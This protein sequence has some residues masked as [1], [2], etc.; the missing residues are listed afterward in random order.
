MIVHTLILIAFVVSC[1]TAPEFNR[2]N[3]YDPKSDN[4]KLDPPTGANYQFDEDGNILLFWEDKSEVETGYRV[5]KSL[6]STSEFTLLAELQENTISF[7]DSTKEFAYPTKYH[8][9]SFFNKIISDTLTIDVDFGEVSRLNAEFNTD[10]S[11]ITLS[12]KDDTFIADGFILNKKTDINQETT[13]VA[14]IPNSSNEYTFKAPKLGFSHNYSLTPFKIFKDDT[15][16]LQPSNSKTISTGP[17]DLELHLISIDSLQIKWKDISD[18]E[19]HFQVTITDQLGT[20]NFEVDKNK[21]SH[22]L[23]KAFITDD[24]VTISVKGVHNSLSSDSIE[25]SIQM[26]LPPP[27]IKRFDIHFSDEGTIVVISDTSLV[28]REKTIYRKINDSEFIEVGTVAKGDSLF[29]D[30][31]LNTSNMY[32]YKVDAPLSNK[33]ALSKSIRFASKFSFVQKKESSKST[34]YSSV[35]LAHNPFK[36]IIAYLTMEDQ[37]ALNIDNYLNEDTPE[38]IP[39]DSRMLNIV[40]DKNATKVAGYSLDDSSKMYIIEISTKVVDSLSIPDSKIIELEFLDSP[41]KI[42]ALIQKSEEN[43]ELISIDLVS[44]AIEPLETINTKN[45]S[46]KLYL[47]D[48]KT[49]LVIKYSLEEPFQDNNVFKIYNLTASGIEL[50]NEKIITQGVNSPLTFSENLDSTMFT[51]SNETELNMYDFQN[52]SFVFKNDYTLDLSSFFRYSTIL[53]NGLIYIQDRHSAFA[54]DTKLKDN[55]IIQHVDFSDGG[56][57]AGTLWNR[58]NN[59]LLDFRRSFNDD[60]KPYYTVFRTEKG[61]SEVIEN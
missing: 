13:F 44:K 40:I 30:N 36:N 45:S 33:T 54:V 5:F 10:Y 12:W 23:N 59:Y 6:G 57:A 47:N 22:I 16:T 4:Y 31:T 2:D 1:S 32:T 21:T 34:T 50:Y 7:K 55:N 27:N 38:E 56:I 46:I 35:L 25:H 37:W 28:R 14:A 43:V 11:E 60:V 61:W 17:K 53:D 42:I 3:E 24:N 26:S 20:E 39:L 9:V 49:K 8:V 58:Q 51:S 48:S 29:I 41:N 15:T 18:F 52:Q 19:E